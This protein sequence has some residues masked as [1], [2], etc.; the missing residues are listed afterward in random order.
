MRKTIITALALILFV[1]QIPMTAYALTA[2]EAKQTWYS[3][4]Q[5]S[6]TAQTAKRQADLD[7]AANTSAENNQKVIEAIQ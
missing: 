7:Y 2:G 3:A 5:A 4:K 1:V 6:A